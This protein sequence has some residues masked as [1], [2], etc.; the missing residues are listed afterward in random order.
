MEP[1]TSH[2]EEDAISRGSPS[3]ILIIAI[4]TNTVF[5]FGS[6]LAEG[7]LGL[8]FGGKSGGHGVGGGVV[9]GGG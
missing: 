7:G 1:S 5:P 3:G 8:F 9:G 2:T 4:E 6:E